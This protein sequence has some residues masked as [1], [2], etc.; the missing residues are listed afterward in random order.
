MIERIGHRG[1]SAVCVA[2][3]RRTETADGFRGSLTV[4]IIGVG[5]LD[6]GVFCLCGDQ[7]DAV[8]LVGT[9][10]A[11][12]AGDLCDIAEVVI[13]HFGD[14]AVVIIELCHIAVLVIRKASCLALCVCLREQIALGV[15]RIGGG[16]T[17]LIGDAERSAHAVG[18]EL[19]RLAV[20]VCA[21]CDHIEAA[22]GLEAEFR[23]IADAVILLRDTVIIIIL[24]DDIRCLLALDGCRD[25]SALF[26]VSVVDLVAC[27]IRQGNELAVLICENCGSAA[28][29][30]DTGHK[31]VVV[32]DERHACTG[33]ILRDL[34]CIAGSAQRDRLILVGL[35]L[36][37]LTVFIKI[38][39]GAVRLFEG[40][41]VVKLTAED[42]AV[43]AAAERDKLLV[44]AVILCIETDQVG[45]QKL[46]VHL[47]VCCCTAEEG[48]MVCR[49][50]VDFDGV[51]AHF[52]MC[53]VVVAPAVADCAA[54]VSI[55]GIVM[56]VES[57]RGKCALHRDCLCFIRECTG[58][59]IDRIAPLVRDNFDLD[60]I[61]GDV[62]RDRRNRDLNIRFLETGHNGVD[63][64]V[65]NLIRIAVTAEC[66]HI[67]AVDCFAR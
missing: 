4:V 31:A 24:V 37:H 16:V 46:T 48:C 57:D 18:L 56:Q 55:Q 13:G 14:I 23:N 52:Q 7:I 35:D 2:V 34:D 1:H 9:L 67:G 30:A 25:Q 44:S 22:V 17:I 39:S 43:H 63:Q 32:G 47:I 51:A 10:L 59:H 8:V 40:K 61:L 38:D 49:I 64:A 58:C 41:G 36:R 54:L 45:C 12:C 60:I 6:T 28:L 19:N 5:A 65:A 62:A 50:P 21:G 20:S 33:H 26:I 27:R 11:A 3:G 53:F 15:I 29:I 42:I 66:C